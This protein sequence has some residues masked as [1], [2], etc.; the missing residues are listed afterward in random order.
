[1]WKFCIRNVLQREDLWDIVNH[2]PAQGVVVAVPAV[3]PAGAN[4][5]A[6]IAAQAEADRLLIRRQRKALS[7]LCLSVTDEII[8]HICELTD[9]V[10]VWTTIRA[11]YETGGNARKPLLKS[12]LFNLK[13]EEGG[14]V[15]EILKEVKDVSNQLIAI[16]EA[17][18]NEEI[19]EHVLNVLPESYEHFISSIGLRDQLPTVTTLT[20]LL[21]HDEAKSYVASD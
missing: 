10:V 14:S 9:P 17:I 4:A 21:L 15:A 13:L 7:I 12:K 1:M 6:V 8:P 11:L 5:A 2:D 16:G 3:L 18:P 20:G 19:V